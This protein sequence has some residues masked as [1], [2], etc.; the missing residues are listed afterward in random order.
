MNLQLLCFRSKKQKN[1]SNGINFFIYNNV[2]FQHTCVAQ[3]Y[4]KKTNLNIK[5]IHFK[6]LEK[7][8]TLF[9]ITGYFLVQVINMYYLILTIALN[10]REDI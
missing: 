9:L 1:I 5:Q 8:F 2:H 3:S 6:A 10:W 4:K 7:A